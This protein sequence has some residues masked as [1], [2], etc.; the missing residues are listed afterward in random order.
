MLTHKNILGQICEFTTG[1]ISSVTVSI[2]K[3]RLHDMAAG[4]DNSAG[5]L[6]EE[7]LRAFLLVLPEEDTWEIATANIEGKGINVLGMEK[8]TTK[9]LTG[10]ALIIIYKSGSTGRIKCGGTLFNRKATFTLEI[11]KDKICMQHK[12]A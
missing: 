1:Q 4:L 9:A 6:S 8:L 7:L 10:I 12:F 2:K 5:S 3:K 11:K